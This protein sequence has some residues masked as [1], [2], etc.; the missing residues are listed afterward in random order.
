MAKVTIFHLPINRFGVFFFEKKTLPLIRDFLDKYTQVCTFET[1]KSDYDA[2]EEAFDL[3]NNPGR[4]EERERIY[5]NGRSLS[6]GD[7]VDVDGVKYACL[8]IGWAKL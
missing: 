8:S 1:D 6:S 7:V 2:A 4:Q 3:T 5:G